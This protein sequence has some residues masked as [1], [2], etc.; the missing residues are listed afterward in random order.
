MNS[1]RDGSHLLRYVCCFKSFCP[2]PRD[3]PFGFLSNS[4][5]CVRGSK[6]IRLDAS[7]LLSASDPLLPVFFFFFC[8]LPVQIK[9]EI[10]FHSVDQKCSNADNLLI[11][12][13]L[14]FQI[15]VI[16]F[17]PVYSLFSV[18]FLGRI[19]VLFSVV[20]I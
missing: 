16:S 5:R 14:I 10:K 20:F 19:R 11:N 2:V 12:C 6:L 4:E 18:F 15:N 7:P 13:V 17:Q 9:P 8:Q 3:N 1:A